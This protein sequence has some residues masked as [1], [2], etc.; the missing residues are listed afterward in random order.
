MYVGIVQLSLFFPY[1]HSLKEKRQALQ[2]IK[3]KLLNQ[4]HI[5][6]AEVEFQDQW[7]RSSLG[8]SLTGGD[9]FHL[10]SVL[11]KAVRFIEEMDLGQVIDCRKEII[12]F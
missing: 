3:S 5:Q 2:K 4:H 1:F 10:D 9:H 11:D 12:S 7:Q 6:A 8:F